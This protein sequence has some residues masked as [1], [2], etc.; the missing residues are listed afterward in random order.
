MGTTINV[1]VKRE[2]RGGSVRG[3]AVLESAQD[4]T[5]EW[6][7][8]HYSHNEWVPGTSSGPLGHSR[9]GTPISHDVVFPLP[10]IRNL[11]SPPAFT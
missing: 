8:T 1:K 4:P 6:S 3:K 5:R 11:T 9:S 7:A 2:N 10:N